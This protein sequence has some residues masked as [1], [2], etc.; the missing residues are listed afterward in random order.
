MCSV[1]EIFYMEKPKRWKTNT[2]FFCQKPTET[3]NMKTV[4]ALNM[5]MMIMLMM[6]S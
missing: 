4:T 3:G 5:S 2:T 1:I 6:T